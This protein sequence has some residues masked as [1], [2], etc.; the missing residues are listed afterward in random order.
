VIGLVGGVVLGLGG[1]ALLGALQAWVLKP[2]QPGPAWLW[3][4]TIAGILITPVAYLLLSLL[5][6]G[7]G[8]VAA[9]LR[10]PSYQA[11][12]P[13]PLLIMAS[14]LVIGAAGGLAFARLTRARA[15][16]GQAAAPND[17]AASQAKVA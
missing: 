11:D 12:S 9:V 16:G 15:A 1:G 13:L 8:A 4:H 5:D 7:Q 2:Y 6:D 17:S 10:G 14:L 3:A